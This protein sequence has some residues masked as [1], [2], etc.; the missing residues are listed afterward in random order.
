MGQCR[1]PLGLSE[2][3]EPS[4]PVLS[5]YEGSLIT[6]LPLPTKWVETGFPAEHLDWAQLLTPSTKTMKSRFQNVTHKCIYSKVQ[7]LC[8]R[9]ASSSYLSRLASFK[10]GDQKEKNSS[11]SKSLVFFFFAITKT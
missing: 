6:H 11:I 4:G 3:G 7:S 1:L 5:N 10:E 2:L 9:A 8:G